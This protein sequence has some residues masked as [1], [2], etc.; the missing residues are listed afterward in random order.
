MNVRELLLLVVAVLGA[1]AGCSVFETRE[2]APPTS[3]EQCP[4]TIP[5][6]PDTLLTNL[7]TTVGCGLSG[8]VNYGR[9]FTEDFVFEADPADVSDLEILLGADPFDGWNKTIEEDVFERIATDVGSN[10]SLRLDL[11]NIEDTGGG[12]ESDASFKADYTLTLKTSAV[13]S[14]VYEGAARFYMVN[15]VTWQINRW[16]DERLG[17]DVTSWGKLKGSNRL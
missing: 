1:G 17:A 4:W 14:T 10:G 7:E 13:D 5:T 8:V 11:T 15:N 9:I 12:E 2:P 16:T 6:E 3:E